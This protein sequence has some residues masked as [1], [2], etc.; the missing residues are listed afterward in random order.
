[1]RKGEFE[2]VLKEGNCLG[3][4]TRI[5]KQGAYQANIL[6]RIADFTPE[7]VYNLLSRREEWPVF[8]P[9]FYLVER[10]TPPGPNQAIYRLA[11]KT[12][13][14]K[15]RMF[16]KQTIIPDE[17]Q[18]RWE[19][20]TPQDISGFD[21]RTE[22]DEKVVARIQGSIT[23]APSPSS[24]GSL[25]LYELFMTAL[26]TG[27]GKE[28]DPFADLQRGQHATMARVPP[29]LMSI[30]AKLAANRDGRDW[31]ISDPAKL[32]EYRSSRDALKGPE[33]EGVRY[34]PKVWVIEK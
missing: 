32:A 13:A 21:L 28:V 26:Q 12:P 17:F 5:A 29:I 9:G 4:W 8:Y 7:E 23:A 33:P 10:L 3:W 31:G 18:V 2:H 6:G 20:P 1:V 24:K 19:G 11:M 22:L 14:G 34:Q 27:T 30:S 16:S 25:V 15:L